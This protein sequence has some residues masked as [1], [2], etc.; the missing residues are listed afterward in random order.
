MVSLSRYPGQI[1]LVLTDQHD[2]Q[3]GIGRPSFASTASR[4]RCSAWSCGSAAWCASAG[5]LQTSNAYLLM[6]A[7]VSTL[8]APR[9]SYGRTAMGIASQAEVRAAQAALARRRAAVEQKAA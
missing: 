3:F 6:P 7:D 2:F 4:S 9:G 8:P 1:D 5:A